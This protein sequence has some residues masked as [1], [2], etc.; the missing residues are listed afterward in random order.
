MGGS[1][2]SVEAM[3]S[4]AGRIAVITGGNGGLGFEAARAM[5]AKGARVVLACRSAAKG[6]EAAA[7]IRAGA[8]DADVAVMPL[9]LADLASVRAFSEAFA[10][11]YPRLDV[12]CN[13]AGVMAIPHQRTKDGFEMQI[14]TNHLGHFALTGVLLPSLREA[15]GAR[16]VTV[17]STVHKLGRV[18]LDD[19]QSERSYGRWPAYAQSKIAN[20]MFAFELDRR[21]AREGVDALSVAA[22]PGY[23]DTNLQIAG[24]GGDATRAGKAFWRFANGSFAQSAADGA[25]PILFAMTDPSVRGGDFFGPRSLFETRGA[26]GPA[27]PVARAKD[28][29]V[30]A[31]LWELSEQLT[32][33]RYL[34]NVA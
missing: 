11:R 5:A 15:P 1:G 10:S 27:K 8:R 18:R 16:V 4:Q 31:Q 19:L 3:P 17:T 33:V 26:P 24:P 7:R 34:S 14:G 25:L 28:E 21:F 29:R 32:S 30:A 2:W 9:D 6:E 20:L 23:A 13:N 12:L 22:H